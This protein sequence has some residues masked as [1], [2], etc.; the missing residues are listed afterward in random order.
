MTS[1]HNVKNILRDFKNDDNQLKILKRKV[2]KKSDIFFKKLY[3]FLP[4]ISGYVRLFNAK[5]DIQELL[6]NNIPSKI[7]LDP[8]YD[9]WIDDMVNLCKIFCFFLGE[10]KV[11]IWIGAHRGCKRYHVDM[12]PYRLLVTYSGQGTELLPNYAAN[13]KAF[14]DGKSNKEIILDETKIKFINK[15]DIAIFRGGK[16]GILHRTPD[17]ALKNFSSVLM[18]LD[19]ASFLEE[20]KKLNGV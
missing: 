4:S 9:I 19:N 13:R 7:K 6:K 18:R 11:S 3:I 20:I 8:F 15:W 16:D 1:Y 2:P 17:S 14:I 12:V 5:K 10:D